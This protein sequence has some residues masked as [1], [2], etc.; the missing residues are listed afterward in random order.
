MHTFYVDELMLSQE[1]AKHAS[2]VL[3]LKPGDEVRVV[4][5]GARWN[6]RLTSLSDKSGEVELLDELPSNE[7]PLRI[8][9]Y[10][11]L[12]KAE[13]L[14]FLAQKLTELGVMRLVPVRMERSVAKA[15]GDKRGD[16]LR[17][18]AREAVKQCG[19]A[20]SMD[21]T[22]PMS[23]KEAL[24]DMNERGLMIVP[25]ENAEA[26]KMSDLKTKFPEVTDIGILIGP[27]GGISEN[28]IKECPAHPVTLGPRILR[29][30]TAAVTSAALAMALWGDI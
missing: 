30:E 7:S 11:G 18:I 4:M 16:R 20:L 23:W 24:A 22:A 14:E 2:R 29:A 27:E 10:Q 15:E 12:P 9:L 1:D 25:W 5:N 3:R 26:T 28:E 17:K 6:A 8:T 13:K 21:I 19:R